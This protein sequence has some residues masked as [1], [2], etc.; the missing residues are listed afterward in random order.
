M[1]GLHCDVWRV[2]VVTVGVGLAANFDS[3]FAV[4]GEPPDGRSCQ[5]GMRQKKAFFGKNVPGNT[6]EAAGRAVLA[7]EA[8]EKA[9]PGTPPAGLRGR[10]GSVRGGGT[11]FWQVNGRKG[12]ENGKNLPKFAEIFQKIDKTP[13]NRPKIYEI[14]KKSAKNGLPNRKKREKTA[15]EPRASA[16]S[17]LSAFAKGLPHAVPPCW[18]SIFQRPPLSSA[19]SAR[20]SVIAGEGVGM[21]GCQGFFH[22]MLCPCRF[23]PPN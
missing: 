9:V 3:K 10:R 18:Q 21:L 8:T 12:I 2:F 1:F 14:S 7:R 22:R 5:A 11:A 20:E 13:K 19:L 15:S 23:S 17:S 16:G 4:G 6:D